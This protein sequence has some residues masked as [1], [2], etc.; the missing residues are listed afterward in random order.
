MNYS[1][2]KSEN[3]YIQ[4]CNKIM[5]LSSQKATRAIN[6]EIELLELLIDKWD[7]ENYAPQE[8]D[9]IELV[10]ILMESKGITRTD[11]TDIL[12]IKKSAL[13]QIL[14]Y[15]KGLSKEV[16]RKL[17]DYFKVSQDAFNRPYQIKS[18]VN[19]GHVNE[20]MMNIPKKLETA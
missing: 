5:E 1:I 6:E 17:S 4:Y 8:K 2:I 12:D 11:L 20:R 14:N 15:H 13:S 9:P 3:Q 10:K 16:I 18:S 7:R 19:K